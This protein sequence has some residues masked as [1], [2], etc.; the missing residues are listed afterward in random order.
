MSV[1]LDIKTAFAGFLNDKIM[2]ETLIIFS[3][4]D[5]EHYVRRLWNAGC[6]PVIEDYSRQELIYYLDNNCVKMPYGRYCISLDEFKGDAVLSEELG[7]ELA[8]K[9]FSL[10][11]DIGA[12][13]NYPYLL[14]KYM[15]FGCFFDVIRE[16]G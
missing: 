16:D 12:R 7:S 4:D 3:P 13:I 15:G 6:G 8:A 9:R 14:L 11:Y 2:A 10:F 5:I 1:A